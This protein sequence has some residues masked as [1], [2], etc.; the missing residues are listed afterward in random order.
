G[1]FTVIYDGAMPGPDYDVFATLRVFSLTGA[2]GILARLAPYSTT[3]ITFGFDS[4]FNAWILAEVVDGVGYPFEFVPAT[5]QPG[6]D[7][8][9]RLR[10]QG[11]TAT[12]YVNGQQVA[13]SPVTITNLHCAGVAFKRSS[14]NPT[15]L[16]LGEWG[17]AV[18]L[19]GV[20][21]DAPAAW[22]I[23]TT[24]G[25]DAPAAW[26]ILTTVGRDAPA[27]WNVRTLVGRDVPLTWN[28]AEA[29]VVTVGRD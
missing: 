23:R 21:R 11:T 16:H 2:A 9:L 10:V 22:N 12:A 19:V 20:G 13:S 1:T 27:A 29:D 8:L 28:V 7:D 14:T 25:R 3:G 24:A 17:T 4:S 6:Q 5:F 26:N 18:S 15:G